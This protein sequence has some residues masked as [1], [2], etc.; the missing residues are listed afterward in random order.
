MPQRGDIQTTTKHVTWVEDEVEMDGADIPDLDVDDSRLDPSISRGNP[1]IAG[2]R[3]Q[4]VH[5]EMACS[6]QDEPPLG[7]D[8]E[9]YD[10]FFWEAPTGEKETESDDRERRTIVLDPTE[11]TATGTTK[12]AVLLRWHRL[13]GHI[14]PHFLL[15]IAPN[16]KGKEEVSRLPAKTKMP[17]CDACEQAKSKKKP[18]EKAT[19][20]RYQEVMYMLHSDLSGRLRVPSIQGARYFVV[21]LDDASNYKFVFLLKTKDKWLE[22]LKRITTMTGRTP[23]VIQTDNAGE[24]TSGECIAYYSDQKIFHKACAPDEHEQNPRAE[25]AIGSL[26]MLCWVMLF[27]SGLAKH[28]WGF[29]IIYAAELENRTLPFKNNSTHTCYE[30]FH[31]APPDNSFLKPFGCAAY[32]HVRKTKR[33]DQKLDNTAILGVFLGLG[34]HMGYKA[35]IIGALDGKRLYITRN[36]VS[37]NEH[38]FPFKKHTVPADG[39]WGTDNPRPETIITTIAGTRLEDMRDDEYCTDDTNFDPEIVTDLEVEE[40]IMLI[41]PEEQ[42]R[43]LT[44]SQHAQRETDETWNKFRAK[45]KKQDK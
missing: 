26:S 19:F 35:Y 31:G 1:G 15:R 20:K 23:K 39:F 12:E 11:K 38:W 13:L 14:N 41:S 44:R 37:F 8:E 22:A 21:F 7:E 17:K 5:E 28:Y 40:E 2:G 6:D 9:L 24:M 3:E 25:S 29:C 45:L 10:D 36:N 27:S 33:K 4:P 30:A 34:F 43:V 42:S 18:R 32:V 16:V